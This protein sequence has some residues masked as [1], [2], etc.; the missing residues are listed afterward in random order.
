MDQ[1]NQEILLRC[2]E[3]LTP[4]FSGVEQ[5]ELLTNLLL[6]CQAASAFQRAYQ[7]IA[8]EGGDPED[9]GAYA[10]KGAVF[11]PP[12]L[13]WEQL[14]SPVQDLKT[15]LLALLMYI[16]RQIPAIRGAVQTGLWEHR[17]SPE[18]LE[19][20]LELYDGWYRRSLSGPFDFAELLEGVLR[21]VPYESAEK[22]FYAPREVCCLLA[23]LLQP[24]GG[25]LYDPCCGAANL[26]A[27]LGEDMARR[28][29]QFSIYGHEIDEQAWKLSK[30]HLYF[31]GLSANLEDRPVNALTLSPDALPKADVVVGNPPFTSKWQQKEDLAFGTDPRWK[32]GVPPKGN[33]NLAWLQHML[34][35]LKDPGVMSVVLNTSSLSS[36]NLSET[37]IRK[38]I[39][40]DGLLEAIL[41]LPSGMF[42]GTSAAVSI[43]ILRKGGRRDQTLMLDARELGVRKSDASSEKRLVLDQAGQQRIL[44]VWQEFC[45][46]GA[47]A[48]T[49]F[50]ASVGLYE[51]EEK[52]WTLDP[53]KYIAYPLPNLP[54]W[55][56]LEQRDAELS[57]ELGELLTENREILRRIRREWEGESE[58]EPGTV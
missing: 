30:I 50:C 44:D 19:R 2:R 15:R 37:R 32:Y 3:V 1:K 17:A 9:E 51:I 16:E 6:A 14:R 55:E 4:L 49:G 22:R 38:G 20:L 40:E 11:F 45:Q 28:C 25:I 5:Q 47:P 36:Q 57:R 42:Y 7:A 31:K 10:A 56:E 58:H 43:W 23:G 48:E 46:G 41:L 34:Y 33:G 54:S 52:N 12:D 35:T 53:R 18:Q 26:L 21:W 39:V 27:P 8:A 13:R 24:Q 29:R